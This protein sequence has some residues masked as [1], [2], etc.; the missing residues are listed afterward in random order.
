MD[1]LASEDQ[2]EYRSVLRIE[3][4]LPVEDDIKSQNCTCTCHCVD[5]IRQNQVQDGNCFILQRPIERV[6]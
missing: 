5:K 6:S 2:R 4:I 1:F 3:E